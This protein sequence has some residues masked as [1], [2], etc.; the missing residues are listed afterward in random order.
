MRP[1]E[2]IHPADVKRNLEE[3]DRLLS[4]KARHV[5]LE[6]R[7]LRKDGGVI[8]IARTVSLVSD[9][10]GSPQYFVS[11]AQDIT[12]LKVAEEKLEAASE[13]SAG[14]MNASRIAIFRWDLHSGT[15]EWDR[16]Q[17]VAGM[18][19]EEVLRTLEGILTLV[20]PEDRAELF[21]R[22]SQSAKEG[23]RFEH[24]FR[25]TLPSNGAIA[26]VYARGSIVRD[27]AGQPECLT[28]ALVDMTEYRVLRR[29]LQDR[30][31][32]LSLAESAGGVHPWA[33]DAITARRIW[34]TN[35]TTVT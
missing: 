26:W 25:V 9:A 29:E 13:F 28:G 23:V 11:V 4:G 5:S 30:Q 2:L 27:Q 8:W 22:L 1:W 14:A 16:T 10:S 6:T 32:L 24:E 17:S 35:S 18:F 15:W 34:W 7:Y 21:E 20:V 12:D 33:V 31:E 3:R 19:P